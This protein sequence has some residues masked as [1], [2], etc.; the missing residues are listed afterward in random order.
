MEDAD[1]MMERLADTMGRRKISQRQLGAAIG[2]TGSAIAQWLARGNEGWLHLR[3]VCRALDVSAD[4]LLGLTDNPRRQGDPRPQT[5][6]AELV[7]RVKEGHLPDVTVRNVK[8]RP[9][10]EP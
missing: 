3:D 7:I 1:D 2:M 9:D 8:R 4:Y 6:G 5:F 10:E